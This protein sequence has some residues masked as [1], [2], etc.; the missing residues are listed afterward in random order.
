MKY[1]I[2]ESFQCNAHDDNAD[3]RKAD[4]GMLKA[5]SIFILFHIDC[6]D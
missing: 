4:F 5:T 1:V 6:S 3:S 2:Y